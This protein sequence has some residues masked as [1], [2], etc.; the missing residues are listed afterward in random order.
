MESKLKAEIIVR[1]VSDNLGVD[2]YRDFFEYNDL[3]IPLAVALKFD[4]CTLTDGGIK[5]LN[6]T[7]SSLCSYVGIDDTYEY[8]SEEDFMADIG[9]LDIDEE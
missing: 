3:G 5:E 1:F 8:K 6:E 4:L 7:Y 9:D 2:E